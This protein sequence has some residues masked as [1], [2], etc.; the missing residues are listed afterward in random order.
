M[1]LGRNRASRQRQSGG[2]TPRTRGVGIA[3]GIFQRRLSRHQFALGLLDGRPPHIRNGR[4]G[5][6]LN[7]DLPAGLATGS[8]ATDD[9]RIVPDLLPDIQLNRRADRC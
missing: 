5:A 1:Q 8:A 3:A 4:R 9:E 7:L 2:T 6:A